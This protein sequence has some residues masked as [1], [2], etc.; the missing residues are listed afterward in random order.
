MDN[1]NTAINQNVDLIST[2]G[3]DE[4]QREQ[5]F[6]IA[7]N[8]FKTFYWGNTIIAAILVLGTIY[9]D[10]NLTLTHACSLIGIAIALLA[11]II[12]IIFAAKTSK[13]GAMNP[14]FINAVSSAKQ[15]IT[16][17]VLGLGYATVSVSRYL[18]GDSVAL[19]YSSIFIAI[20][21]ASH[22]ITYFLA[23]K[24]VKLMNEETENDE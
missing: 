3:L 11:S 10:E 24:S 5:A 2:N 7:F 6:K 18:D 13:A 17:T 12:Y 8:C 14:Y 22:I 9:F 21:Y 1:K 20:F 19:L 15:I 23:K 16:M 4:M